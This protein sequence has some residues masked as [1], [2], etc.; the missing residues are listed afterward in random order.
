MET[1]HNRSRRGFLGATA[2]GAFADELTRT[3]TTIEGPFFPNTLL[4]DADN[5]LP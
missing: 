5:D 3:P 4:L 2:L 1:T